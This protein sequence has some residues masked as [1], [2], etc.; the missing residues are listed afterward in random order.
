[1]KNVKYQRKPTAYE[2]EALDQLQQALDL[3]N[4][5][6]KRLRNFLIKGELELQISNGLLLIGIP[7]TKKIDEQ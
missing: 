6:Y 4:N 1:M 2:A 5:K 3:S 7:K